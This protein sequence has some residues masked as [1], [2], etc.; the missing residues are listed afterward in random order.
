MS[1]E[2]G[3]GKPLSKSL[4]LSVSVSKEGQKIQGTI[5]K[6]GNQEGRGQYPLC[7]SAPLRETCF[8][9]WRPS[10]PRSQ[11]NMAG[12][13]SVARHGVARFRG[14][15]VVRS[16]GFPKKHFRGTGGRTAPAAEENRM[17]TC[18]AEARGRRDVLPVHMPLA[19]E[20]E[21]PN[22]RNKGSKQNPEF[23]RAGKMRQRAHCLFF[24]HSILNTDY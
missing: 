2:L 24:S 14:L 16:P 21:Y 9:L 4:S 22:P 15:C 19:F 23:R 11:G 10:R 6:S 8:C 7:A 20:G 1:F 12:A 5:W 17:N 13:S 3:R 18:R